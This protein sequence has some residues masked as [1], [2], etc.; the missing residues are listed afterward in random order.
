MPTHAAV[1][2]GDLGPQTLRYPE[3]A[4]RDRHGPVGGAEAR[5]M[6]RRLELDVVSAAAALLDTGISGRVSPR[7]V[8][9]LRAVRRIRA[10]GGPRVPHRLFLRRRVFPP[11]RGSAGADRAGFHNGVPGAG[12]LQYSRLLHSASPAAAPTD[13]LDGNGGP[14]A[15]GG[16][17]PEAGAR[18][19]PRLAGAV[20]PGRRLGAAGLSRRHCS[21]DAAGPRQ[22]A[23]DAPRHRLWHGPGHREPAEVARRRSAQRHPRLRGVRRPGRGEGRPLGCR[24]SQPRQP[25]G[26]DALLPASAH[27]HAGGGAA[28]V[29]GEARARARQEAVGAADRHPAGR[30]RLHAEASPARLLLRRRR[31]ADRPHRQAHR[32]L[33]RDPQVAVRQGVAARR[34][35]PWRR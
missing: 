13:G 28:A 16:L 34:C 29:R 24:L 6:P 32:R 22:G 27:R 35:S 7:R 21:A 33:G 26:A 12:A 30:P 31:A 11:V 8:C 1:A 20:V 15:G 3:G 4:P 14:A 9:R 2:E 23:P 19:F 25:R 5:S 17:L 10:A 18:V